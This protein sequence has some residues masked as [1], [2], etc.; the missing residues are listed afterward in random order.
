M[1]LADALATVFY[2][3]GGRVE[4]LVKLQIAMYMLHRETHLVETRFETWYT[5]PWSE[6]V[7]RAVEELARGGLLATEGGPETYVASK[8]LL[9]R[10]GETYRE[11]EE[12][13]PY[14][15]RLMKLIVAYATSLPLG[16]LILAVRLMYPETAQSGANWPKLL[17]NARNP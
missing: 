5:A 15:A 2:L 16:K 3:A 11:I 14:T 10:G 13:D 4:G 1:R 12:R 17:C 8:Q 9:E 7:E 6:D